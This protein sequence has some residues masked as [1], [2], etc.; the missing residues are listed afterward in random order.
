MLMLNEAQV[1]RVKLTSVT[2]MS[3]R[4]GQPILEMGL[5]TAMFEAAAI[6]ALVQM[7]RRAAMRVLR[8]ILATTA[9]VRTE[10]LHV[11]TTYRNEL[12]YRCV[13]TSLCTMR[14][15]EQSCLRAC[16][17]SANRTCV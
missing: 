2:C 5:Y 13:R 16:D 15:C 11:D 7:V 14:T 10:K 1:V 8:N 9:K 6:R 3:A 12:R 17:K 4:S